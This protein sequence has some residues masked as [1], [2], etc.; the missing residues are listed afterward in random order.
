MNYKGG[1]LVFYFLC[2]LVFIELIAIIF[3]LTGGITV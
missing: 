3:L 2:V 1:F